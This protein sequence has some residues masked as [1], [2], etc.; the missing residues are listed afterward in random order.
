MKIHSQQHI[1][2]WK[3]R[4]IS[5]FMLAFHTGLSCCG[6]RPSGTNLSFT[7]TLEPEVSSLLLWFVS[8]PSWPPSFLLYWVET[9]KCTTSWDTLERS[10]C[11]AAEFSTWMTKQL[12]ELQGVSLNLLFIWRHQI[13]RGKGSESLYT[14]LK[15]L[16]ENTMQYCLGDLVCIVREW[17]GKQ[18]NGEL[19]KRKKA[20]T[21]KS[22]KITKVKPPWYSSFFYLFCLFG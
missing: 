19:I 6:K 2:K 21:E 4:I 16:F 10:V 5:N 12:M 17:N 14:V 22:F 20:K 8:P 7:Q 18:R 11:K 1:L 9:A 3:S 15:V 13:K